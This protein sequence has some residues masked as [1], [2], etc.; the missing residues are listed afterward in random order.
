MVEVIMRRP[1]LILITLASSSLLS[2]QSWSAWK[3]DPVFQGIQVREHCG[4]FNEFANRYMWD[5][6]LRNTYKKDIDMS[7]AA[8]P[9]RLHGAE[10]QIDHAV[11]VKPGEV[12]EAHHT[13]PN[14]CSAGLLVKVNE[15]KAAGG[16]AAVTAGA[17]SLRPKLQ[18]R[19][20]SKDPEPLRKELVVELSGRTVTSSYSSPNFSIQI[21][22]PLPDGVSGSVSLERSETK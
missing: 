12:V 1:P 7:W 8:E 3:P 19:W 6:E 11:A 5:V 15:V 21:S 16:P 22:S 20:T 10:A 9:G 17:S 14:A 2:A 4:G 13:A 18:G